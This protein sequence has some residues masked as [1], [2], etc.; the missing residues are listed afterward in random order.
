MSNHDNFIREDS[1]NSEELLEKSKLAIR[2]LL[3]IQNNN[4]LL[5]ESYCLEDSRSSIFKIEKGS[6]N[7]PA[8]YL[9]RNTYHNI[10][11]RIELK[12]SH[13][14][15]A[16]QFAYLDYF[17]LATS[18]FDSKDM[19]LGGETVYV[20]DL[21]PK[22]T[23]PIT[24]PIEIKSEENLPMDLNKNPVYLIGPPNNKRD[25]VTQKNLKLLYLNKIR[26]S[27]ARLLSHGR[28]GVDLLRMEER[29]YGWMEEI[30]E[31]SQEDNIKKL[32]ELNKKYPHISSIDPNRLEKHFD[33]L[34]A[35]KEVVKERMKRNLTYGKHVAYK[36]YV[37]LIRI[38]TLLIEI[39]RPNFFTRNH[40]MEMFNFD[41]VTLRALI[42]IKAGHRYTDE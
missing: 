41:F 20:P 12:F 5:P 30:F 28:S 21:M 19:F 2:N 29:A 37:D 26:T 32:K 9:Y 35:E 3:R 10:S 4:L 34:D 14:D 27:I 31:S 36:T 25:L 8:V 38:M 13:P 6:E 39:S 42:S 24:N 1:I 18:N 17:L 7:G 15:N 40:Y 23:N 11:V 16:H 33:H 22:D